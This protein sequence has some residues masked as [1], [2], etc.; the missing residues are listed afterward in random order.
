MEGKQWR[1]KASNSEPVASS[2]AKARRWHPDQP[3]VAA[4]A[5]FKLLSVSKLI[6]YIF[7]QRFFGLSVR[8]CLKLV[9]SKS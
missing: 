3:A 6:D 2:A 9:P 1:K 8:N 4:K 5:R 7:N